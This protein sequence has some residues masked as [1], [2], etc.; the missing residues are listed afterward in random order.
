[1]KNLPWMEAFYER[2]NCC[3]PARLL[4][5][6]KAGVCHGSVLG[7]PSHVE[8]TTHF[9]VEVLVIRQICTNL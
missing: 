3:V 5:G 8:G 2:A 7:L 4:R 9:L 1:M 6:G